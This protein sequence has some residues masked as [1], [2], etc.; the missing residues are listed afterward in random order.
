MFVQQDDIAAFV[1]H[2]F[3]AILRLS[4]LAVRV[5]EQGCWDGKIGV[6]HDAG[7]G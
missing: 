2:I 5:A 6:G 4:V 7:D 3:Y 1:D